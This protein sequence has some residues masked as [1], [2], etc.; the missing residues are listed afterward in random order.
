MQL[1]DLSIPRQHAF[2]AM[3][4]G[5]LEPRE[6]KAREPKAFAFPNP[7]I[8]M[9]EIIRPKPSASTD[10][11][12]SPI[13]AFSVDL[14]SGGKIKFVTPQNVAKGPEPRAKRPWARAGDTKD[15]RIAVRLTTEGVRR[16]YALHDILETDRVYGRAP[17]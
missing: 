8:H 11:L 5:G 14:R 1:Q 3:L 2:L 6:D 4:M 13:A 16:L 17:R 10:V 7:V 15:G 9:A 12:S